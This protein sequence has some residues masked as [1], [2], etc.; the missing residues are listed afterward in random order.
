VSLRAL[1]HAKD[2]LEL[3]AHTLEVLWACR[4]GGVAEDQGSHEPEERTD[5]CME[6]GC[7][8]YHKRVPPPRIYTRHYSSE[9]SKFMIHL[10]NG[11]R[12]VPSDCL[13]VFIMEIMK[14]TTVETF[15]LSQGNVRQASQ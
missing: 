8:K 9:K 4:E 5:G 15:P 1:H 10:I 3:P 7:D 12:R 6:Q 14:Q 2:V 13:S 11:N